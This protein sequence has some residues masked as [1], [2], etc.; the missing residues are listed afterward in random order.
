[1]AAKRNLGLQL[2]Q[3]VLV[4]SR[5]PL[6][7]CS[8]QTY[9]SLWLSS[10]LARILQCTSMEPAGTVQHPSELLH[11]S[12]I[13]QRSTCSKATQSAR[14]A[15]TRNDGNAEQHRTLL[16][17]RR[18]CCWLYNSIECSALMDCTTQ[19]FPWTACTSSV[20][21]STSSSEDTTKQVASY[22]SISPE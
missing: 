7:F 1:M 5:H 16:R 2:V 20:S 15:F 14:I 18:D 21:S 19:L 4:H 22:N 9:Q 12:L 8:L 13:S 3:E 6:R 11:S 10:R 17:F